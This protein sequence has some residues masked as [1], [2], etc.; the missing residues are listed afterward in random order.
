MR[1]LALR[2]QGLLFVLL[3]TAAVALTA[4]LA[5]RHRVSWHW[6]GGA[7]LGE[8]SLRLLEH[9]RDPVSAVG[10]VTPGHLLERHLRDLLARY[11]AAAPGFHFELVNPQ[12]RPDLVREFGIERSG[13]IVLAYGGRSERVKV[14]T[15]QHLSAALERLLR[16][17][18][19]F[20]AYLS[21]HGERDLLGEANHD[22]GAF[23]RA[24]SQKG[25]RLQPISLARL[26]AVPDS[27]D[28]LVLASPQT[29]LLPAELRRLAEYLERGGR[30]LWLADPE[31]PALLPP[32]AEALGLSWQDGVVVD[33]MAAVTL[34]VDDARLVLVSEH[35]GHPVTARLAGP[36][37]LPQTKA[38]VPPERGWRSTP[39]VVAAEGQFL[40]ADYR[41]GATLRRSQSAPPLIL[42]AALS[43]ALERGEQRVAVLG[44]GDL[45]SN[46]YLGN[47]ANLQLGLNLVDWLIESELFLDTYA[48]A[49]PDQELALSRRALVGMGFGFL[50]GVPGLAFT[51]AGWLWLRRRSG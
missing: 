40:A 17:P 36:L 22:L 13:E 12:T 37:L 6:G 41:P 1:A 39:L 46:Q 10:F 3:L 26:P 27:A 20:I 35:A 24:L 38:F 31:P 7:S 15:E 9:I 14:P 8:P 11:A 28:L 43:R 30:L 33:P 50:L 5:E 34:G 4:W 49:A 45:L 2:L 16:G 32:L 21:G 29:E 19:R 51:L 47:G 42:G 18:D 25:Y 44:D 23:G 48:R